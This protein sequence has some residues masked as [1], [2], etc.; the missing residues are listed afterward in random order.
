[1]LPGRCAIVTRMKEAKISAITRLHLILLAINSH[2]GVSLLVIGTICQ[3]HRKG[4]TFVMPSCASD[5][6]APHPTHLIEW[7]IWHPT[8]TQIGDACGCFTTHLLV[9]SNPKV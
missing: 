1:M 4:T 9:P 3:L 6:V 5:K 2:H 8:Q 7:Y